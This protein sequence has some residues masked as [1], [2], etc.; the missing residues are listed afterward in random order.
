IIL[1]KEN[2]LWNENYI[3]TLKRNIAFLT[4]RQLIK[5]KGKIPDEIKKLAHDDKTFYHWFPLALIQ[6]IIGKPLGIYKPD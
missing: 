1:S 5:T 4:L 2:S 6:V 3:K